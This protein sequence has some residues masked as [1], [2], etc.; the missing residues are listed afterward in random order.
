MNINWKKDMASIAE[1][2]SLKTLLPTANNL[3]RRLP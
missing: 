1:I 2:E 3:N